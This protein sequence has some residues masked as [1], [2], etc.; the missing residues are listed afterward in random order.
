ML[1]F[2]CE[3]SR[4]GK[5]AGAGAGAGDVIKPFTRVIDGSRKR[6][7]RNQKKTFRSPLS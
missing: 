4:D 2:T 3:V 5:G 1:V 6:R 7:R